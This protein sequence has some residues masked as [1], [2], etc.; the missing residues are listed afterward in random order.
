VHVFKRRY[1][2]KAK[3]LYIKIKRSVFWNPIIRV[4][5]IGCLDLDFYAV[6][7][8][9][10]LYLYYS[11]PNDLPSPDRILETAASIN[12]KKQTFPI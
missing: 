5:L 4:Y 6:E 10:Q 12:E 1:P 2:E 9:K 7:G 8:I 3:E 11:N